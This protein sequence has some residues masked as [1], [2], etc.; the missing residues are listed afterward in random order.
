MKILLPSLLL[1]SLLA[2]SCSK[3]KDFVLPPQPNV[4]NNQ[5]SS[6][7][8]VVSLKLN[9]HAVSFPS[10]TIS[11]SVANGDLGFI[12]E[13]DSVKLELKINSI[14]QT[15]NSTGLVLIGLYSWKLYRKLPENTYEELVTTDK[16]L[17]IYSNRPLTDNVVTGEFKFIA[18][19]PQEITA[20]LITEGKFKLV[21]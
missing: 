17:G 9:G 5:A 7:A 20:N 6:P 21:F 18:V 16:W 15:S 14:L 11:R 3:Q 8:S 2:L 1:S 4:V 13:N 10:I 19:A 12:A